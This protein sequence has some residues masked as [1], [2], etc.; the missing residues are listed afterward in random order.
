MIHS[1]LSKRNKTICPHK[2]LYAD[3]H[4][5]FFHKSQKLESTQMSNSRWMGIQSVMYPHN[6]I[7]PRSKRQWTPDTSVKYMNLKELCQMNDTACFHLLRILKNPKDTKISGC[8][9][10]SQSLEMKKYKET[11]ETLGVAEM[12]IVSMVVMVSWVY[13]DI[14]VITLYA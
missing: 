12:S 5:S 3:I 2:D 6:G 11:Q 9:A 13:A 14:K 8:L 1:Y 7:L 4:N 10:S